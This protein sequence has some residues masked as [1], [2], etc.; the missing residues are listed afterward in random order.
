MDH[1]MIHHGDS[2]Q[3]SGRPEGPEKAPLDYLS[4]VPASAG[5]SASKHDVP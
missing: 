1:V 2:V 4:I 5:T 3:V